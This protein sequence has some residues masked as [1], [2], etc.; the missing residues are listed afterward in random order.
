MN[1]VVSLELLAGLFLALTFGGM[2]FFSAVVA[3][4]VFKKLQPATAGAFIREVFPCYYTTMGG[5]TLV[6]FLTLLPAAG[7]TGAWPA[8]LSGLTLVGFLFARLVLMPTINRS[9]D[10][11]LAG[12]AAAGRR[13]RRVHG[14]SVAMNAGQ[15]LAVTVALWLVLL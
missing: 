15:W 11:E 9:R 1:D 3:P 12:D 14:L 6:A 13:F 7:S 5:I 4:L 10:R 2:T 8:V